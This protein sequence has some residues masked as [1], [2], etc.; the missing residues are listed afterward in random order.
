LS[1]WLE[2]LRDR[3]IV[4][5]QVAKRKLD[6][7]LGRREL[8]R[9]LYAVGAAFMALVKEGRVVVPTEM[10]SVVRDARELEEQIEAHRGEIVA[11]QSEG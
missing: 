6:A 2:E 8:D 1:N 10:A 5:S 11:L 7:A 3:I 4:R 9:R